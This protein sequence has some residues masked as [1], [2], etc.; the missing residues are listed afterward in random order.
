MWALSNLCILLSALEIFI[1]VVD[2]S[3]AFLSILAHVFSKT[4][5]ELFFN[6]TEL[7]PSITITP[8]KDKMNRTYKQKQKFGQHLFFLKNEQQDTGIVQPNTIIVSKDI[9]KNDSSIKSDAFKVTF[10]SIPAVLF[11]F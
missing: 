3:V 5:L 6:Q 9:A 4:P 2:K 8:I 11:A 7:T 1:S 10:D